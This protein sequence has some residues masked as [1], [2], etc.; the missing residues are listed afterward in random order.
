MTFANPAA[1]GLLALAIPIVLLH[2]LRPRREQRTVSS[3]Y[4]WRAVGPPGQRGAAVAAAPAVVAAVPPAAGR[5]PAR[6]GG[7]RPGAGGRGAAGRAHRLHRRCVGVDGATDGDTDPARRGPGRGDAPP[8]ASC[9][10]AAWPR[11]S[12]STATRGR[13][14]PPAPTRP[15]STGCCARSSPPRAAPTGPRPSTRRCSSTPSAPRSASTS[16]PT[17]AAWPAAVVERLIPEGSRHTIVGERSTNRAVTALVVEQRGSQLHATA[18]VQQHRRRR[19]HRPGCA[20]GSTASSPRRCRSAPRRAPP[21]RSRSTCPVGDRVEAFLRATT[22]STSTTAPS[23]PPPDGARVT[24][25]LCSPS[26]RANPFLQ[27]ALEASEG[28]TVEA[29]DGTQPRHRRRPRDLRPGARAGRRRRP[30]RRRRPAGRR[31]GRGHHRRT[32]PAETLAVTTIASGDALVDGLDLAE[33]SVAAAE[34]WDT[35]TSTVVV[36]SNDVPLVVRGTTGGLPF[37]ALSFSVLPENTNLPLLIA[38]PLLVDRLVTELAAA[39]VPPTGVVV[40]D[41]LPVERQLRW[42]RHRARRDRARGRARRAGARRRPARLLGDRE[43][44]SGPSG[45]SR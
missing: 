11:S 8:A 37:A 26:E 15:S 36:A 38:F 33:V 41:A 28:V 19:R 6:R 12:S 20:S 45:S 22:S 1:L 7:R 34:R 29:C 35:G 25:L 14:S 27:G 9:P 5:R 3:T 16:S 10:T 31:P 32:A 13:C 21:R 40:D 2:V 39:A 43:R 17:A 30:V 42:H 23:P 44:R 24:V 18:T 4:L